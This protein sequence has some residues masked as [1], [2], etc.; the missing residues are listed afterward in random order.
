MFGRVAADAIP[1][2]PGSAEEAAATAAAAAE[3]ARNCRRPTPLALLPRSC[4]SSFMF[5]TPLTDGDM[6][7]TDGN[8]SLDKHTG[9]REGERETGSQRE[10]FEL[11]LK[12]I[13]KLE[14]WTRTHRKHR[15]RQG[16]TLPLRRLYGEGRTERARLPLK[17]DMQA[18]DQKVTRSHKRTV[19]NCPPARQSR[20]L[21]Y[22]RKKV[23]PTAIGQ[24][25]D[26]AR[27]RLNVTRGL[28]SALVISHRV[29]GCPHIRAR[30]AHP[31]LGQVLA[32]PSG[33]RLKRLRYEPKR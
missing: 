3:P 18:S 8:E 15:G 32:Q 1:P 13:S 14:P 27:L 29:C 10:E 26:G 9:R 24:C 4:C 16:N 17:I 31:T 22:F 30:P 2:I 12:V 20:E 21:T 6:P 25:L 19:M 11:H 33:S 23:H 5:L 7:P 28:S